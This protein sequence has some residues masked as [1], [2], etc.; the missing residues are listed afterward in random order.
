MISSFIT[1]LQCE[2]NYSAHTVD[3]Y[4]HDLEEWACFATSGNMDELDAASVTVS[5]LRLWIAALAQ[6][7]AVSIVIKTKGA[8]FA[9][10]F[11]LPYA[12]PRSNTQSGFRPHFG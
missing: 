3:A 5:D 1:Y 9:C 10:I 4:R 6:K 2:L 12:V 11:P 8:K 7:R